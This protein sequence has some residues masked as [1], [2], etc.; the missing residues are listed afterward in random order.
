MEKPLVNKKEQLQ[1]F[2]G[3]G[4]WTFVAIPEVLQDK[5]SP[6]GWVTVK[7]SIDDYAIKNYK[8]QPMGN[9]KLFLPVKAQIRKIIQKQAGDFV[10]VIL[11]KEDAP[12]EIP[13]E[14][15]SCLLDE[16]N[17]YEK[18]TVYTQG[19]QKEFIDWIYAAKK[20]ETKV[21]RIVIV[22]NKV[23]KNERLRTKQK[24]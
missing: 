15:K 10:Q 4:G 17:A 18:F 16:P 14:L 6:F 24:V 3:K 23:L 22:I 20:V 2:P 9:G 5:T 7:G 21:A 1:K 11:Y 19:Q 13:S 12:I 8:L